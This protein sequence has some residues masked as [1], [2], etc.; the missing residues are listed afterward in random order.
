MRRPAT[1]LLAGLAAGL[2]ALAIAGPAVAAGPRPQVTKGEVIAAFQARTTG[3]FV[4]GLAGRTVSAPARGLRDGRISSFRSD[5][6]YCSS[7]WHY[8][9]VTYLGS[10]GRAAATA[11]LR[12]TGAQF[13]IDGTPVAVTMRT[14]IKRFVDGVRGDFG[15]SYG[16]LVPP[17]SLT[18]GWHTL[19]TDFIAPG[20]NSQLV[21]AFE[22]VASPC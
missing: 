17:G 2:L 19:T 12:Q 20:G 7:D 8:L 13:E 21:V 18:P 4:N 5:V 14:A 11:F 15:I 3:G 6:S 9:G 16:T 1:R 22:I 10:G